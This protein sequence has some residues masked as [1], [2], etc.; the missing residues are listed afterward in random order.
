MQ[1]IP[2]TNLPSTVPQPPLSSNTTPSPPLS[3]ILQ[4]FDWDPA[5]LS[6]LSF[7]SFALIF[8]LCLASGTHYQRF[9]SI[10]DRQSKA[11]IT[12]KRGHTRWAKQKRGLI[13]TIPIPS[14]PVSHWESMYFLSLLTPYP[15]QLQR[16]A[17]F[18]LFAPSCRQF[19]TERKWEISRVVLCWVRLNKTISM[20]SYAR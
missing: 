11:S 10:R 7:Y 5:C 16:S 2:P 12:K 6:F 14:L 19:L 15:R 20:A 18:F 3:S 9:D 8:I 4:S 1:P 17:T 13:Q